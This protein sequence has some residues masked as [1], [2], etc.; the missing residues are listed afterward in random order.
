MVDDPLATAMKSWQMS[1]RRRFETEEMPPA[2]SP[3]ASRLSVI[4]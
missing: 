1:V 3:A 4:M 2:K